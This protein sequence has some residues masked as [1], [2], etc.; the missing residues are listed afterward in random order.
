MRL[1]SW[2][3]V[4]RRCASW[5]EADEQCYYIYIFVEKRKIE[6]QSDLP[7]IRRSGGGQAFVWVDGGVMLP[8][9]VTVEN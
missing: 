8:G 9:L 7:A 1:E 3:K 6:Y 4:P 5:G 2:E